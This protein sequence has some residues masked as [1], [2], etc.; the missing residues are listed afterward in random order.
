MLYMPEAEA[1]WNAPRSFKSLNL[2]ILPLTRL[3]RKKQTFRLDRP[4]SG[5]YAQPD[6]LIDSP[7]KLDI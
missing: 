1:R 3:F 7:N 2:A 4:I 5:H 6:H